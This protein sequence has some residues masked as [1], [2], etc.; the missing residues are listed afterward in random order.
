MTRKL[1]L[2]LQ[3]RTHLVVAFVGILMTACG[4]GLAHLRGWD[5]SQNTVVFL[6]LPLGIAICLLVMELI[7]SICRWN[8]S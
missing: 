1:K 5:L 6:S 2:F 4:F 3:D 8:A 7:E